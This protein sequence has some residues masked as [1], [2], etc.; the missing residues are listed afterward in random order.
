MNELLRPNTSDMFNRFWTMFCHGMTM[1]SIVRC[2]SGCPNS[3]ILSFGK[4]VAPS[5][6]LLAQHERDFVDKTGSYPEAEA[7]NADPLSKPLVAAW[8]N[9][10]RRKNPQPPLLILEAVRDST[11]SSS[12]ILSENRR[13]HRIRLQNDE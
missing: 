13:S 11:T 5:I 8:E 9:L 10:C 4:K 7:S 1:Q 3:P 2:L 6:I 12:R